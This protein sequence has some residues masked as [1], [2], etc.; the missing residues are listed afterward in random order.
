MTGVQTCALPICPADKAGL[1]QGDIITGV[2]NE[3][4]IIQDDK[5]RSEANRAISLISGSPAGKLIVLEIYRDGGF[6]QLPTILGVGRPNFSGVE[7]IADSVEDQTAGQEI[8][9]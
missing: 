7:R 5:D 1:H 3:K 8:Q 6:V 4:I 9:Q 2:D